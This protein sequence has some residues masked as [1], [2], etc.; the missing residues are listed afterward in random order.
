MKGSFGDA[1]P[2]EILKSAIG[3]KRKK[4]DFKQFQTAADNL[5]RV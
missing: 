4:L 2:H 5:E 1:V 3:C